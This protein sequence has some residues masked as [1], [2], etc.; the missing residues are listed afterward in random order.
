[1]AREE[2]ASS[3]GSTYDMFLLAS[4]AD[5]MTMVGGSYSQYGT[6]AVVVK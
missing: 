2:V 6:G 1:M 4:L 5:T 3:E